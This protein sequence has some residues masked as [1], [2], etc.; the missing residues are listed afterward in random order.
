ML[1]VGSG[2]SLL[3]FVALF[4]GDGGSSVWTAAATFAVTNGFGHHVRMVMIPLVVVG[5][6]RAAGVGHGMHGVLDNMVDAAISFAGGHLL[7]SGKDDVFLFFSA[8]ITTAGVSCCWIGVH[9]LER[10]SSFIKM[11][12]AKI[13]ETTA[14]DLHSSLLAEIIQPSFIERP[15]A[16]VIETTMADLDSTS[17]AEIALPS[18]SMLVADPWG[19][20]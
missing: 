2:V 13:I 8:S 14:A 12:D 15:L 5:A 1:A 9:L 7:E 17:L 20:A 19:E 16:K 4:T 11:P 3:G 6:S 18:K 10:R